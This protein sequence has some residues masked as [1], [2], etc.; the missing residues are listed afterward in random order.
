[1]GLYQKCH[2]LS[3]VPYGT[4]KLCRRD[5]WPQRIERGLLLVLMVRMLL[6][7]AVRGCTGDGAACSLCKVDVLSASVLPKPKTLRPIRVVNCHRVDSNQQSVAHVKLSHSQVVIR[8]VDKILHDPECRYY[9]TIF[10]SLGMQ[11]HD[12]FCASPVCMI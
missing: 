3:G 7:E 11:G 5:E 9:S 6:E 2:L 10:L 1:M 4:A 8:S 12:G